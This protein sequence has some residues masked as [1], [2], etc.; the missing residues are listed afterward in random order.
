MDNFTIGY[1]KDA[2]TNF[3]KGVMEKHSIFN[4]G[5]KDVCDF[6]M[7][8]IE[9]EVMKAKTGNCKQF[10][11]GIDDGKLEKAICKSIAYIDAWKKAKAEQKKAEAKAKTVETKTE[12]KKATYSKPTKPNNKP[13]K[14]EDVEEFDITQLELF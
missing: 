1:D 4:V 10:T 11:F 5:E 7:E 8:A 13:K 3:V 14:E 2:F 6:I 12:P 9:A